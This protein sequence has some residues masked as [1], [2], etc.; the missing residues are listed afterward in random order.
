MQINIKATNLEMTPALEDYIRE[1]VNMLKKYLGNTVKANQI[2]FEIEKFV[3][4]QK[5][6][7][8]YRAEANVDVPGKVI[9]VEK[10]EA[11]MYAAID[12]VKDNLEITIRR[13]KEKLIDKRRGRA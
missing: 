1:K 8:I 7:Q 3:G 13:Y 9:R 2:D 10:E 11:D 5:K 12:R 4:N 6:G